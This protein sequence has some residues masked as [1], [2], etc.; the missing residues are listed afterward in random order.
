MTNPKGAD[1]A[2]LDDCLL[3]LAQSGGGL[4]VEDFRERIIRQAIHAEAAVRLAVYLFGS[5]FMAVLVLALFFVGRLDG[6]AW[7]VVWA[8][9]LGGLGSVASIL[10]HV[11]KLRPHDTP[12]RPDG[13]EAV[14]RIFLGC[15]FSLVLSLAF[16]AKPLLDFYQFMAG[17]GDAPAVGVQLLLPFLCGYSIPLVLGLLDKAIQAVEITLGLTQAPLGRR[18]KQRRAS[19]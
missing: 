9:S 10:L 15:I 18:V 12:Q 13:L 5:A 7:I 11:L 17:R 2:K 4:T 6:S 14:G 3:I 19:P 16:V 1:R 8:L